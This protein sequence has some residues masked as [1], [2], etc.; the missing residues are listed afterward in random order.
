MLRATCY[1]NQML[2]KENRLK[3]SS[4]IQKVFKFGKQTRSGFLF[5]KYLSNKREVSRFAF[6]VGMKYSK[7]AVK[8]NEL[9]RIL[10]ALAKKRLPKVKNGLDI[11]VGPINLRPEE[12]DREVLRNDIEKLFKIADLI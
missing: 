9:K 8:R 5:L 10:R 1:A 4:E 12:I 7:S 2:P 6:A 3:S 11:V